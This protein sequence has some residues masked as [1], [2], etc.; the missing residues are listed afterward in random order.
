MLA[1]AIESEP[2]ANSDLP[3]LPRKYIEMTKFPKMSNPLMIMGNAV[4][5]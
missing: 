4:V 3:I 5:K 1:M 2:Q